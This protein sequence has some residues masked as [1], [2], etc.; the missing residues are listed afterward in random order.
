MAKVGSAK[1]ERIEIILAQALGAYEEL[2]EVV[3]G[4]HAWSDAERMSYV[5][6]WFLMEQSIEDLERNVAGMNPKQRRRLEEL[7]DAVKSHRGEAE[8]VKSLAA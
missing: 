3:R 7:R 4:I 1:Q 8:F 6:D 2:P 5:Y